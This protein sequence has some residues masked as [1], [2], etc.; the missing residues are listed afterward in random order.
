MRG[1]NMMS[2]WQYQPVSFT[3]LYLKA[4]TLKIEKPVIGLRYSSQATS[5]IN[6]R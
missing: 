3:W 6:M 5:L 2:G 1:L 4:K